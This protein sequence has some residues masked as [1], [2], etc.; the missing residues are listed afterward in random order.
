MNVQALPVIR[1][2]PFRSDL[3][4]SPSWNLPL[5]ICSAMKI[6]RPALHQRFP[7]SASLRSGRTESPPSPR[8]SPILHKFRSF[9]PTI[10]RPSP[11]HCAS[12]HPPASNRAESGAHPPPDTLPFLLSEKQCTN[13]TSI[14]LTSASRHPPAS[15]QAQPGTHPPPSDSL[16]PE[17]NINIF[18]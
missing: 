6:Q 15:R 1:Q 5:S 10:K 4:V 13:A 18:L 8:P 2:P 14:T 16:L 3:A 11:F 9:R 12:R 17:K 7:S